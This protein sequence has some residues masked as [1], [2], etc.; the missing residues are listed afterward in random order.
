MFELAIMRATFTKTH[1]SAALGQ[2]K[3]SNGESTKASQGGA[4]N[5]N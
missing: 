2:A 5:G 3:R 1:T 4:K